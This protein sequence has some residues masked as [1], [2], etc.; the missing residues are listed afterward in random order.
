ML[1]DAKFKFKQATPLL[2]D[3]IWN[4]GRIRIKRH[5]NEMYYNEVQSGGATFWL[6]HRRAGLCECHAASALH[7]R[8]AS[9]L[10]TLDGLDGPDAQD[11]DALV[12][13]RTDEKQSV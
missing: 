1:N 7:G 12:V 2:S 10:C 11:D 4:T 13:W 5:I 8:N 3:A 9:W 6:Q